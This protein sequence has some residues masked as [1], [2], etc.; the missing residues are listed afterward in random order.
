MKA[1]D[2]KG[3]WTPNEFFLLPGLNFCDRFVLSCIYGLDDNGCTAGDDYIGSL[4]AATKVQV[5]NSINKMKRLGFIQVDCFRGKGILGTQRKIYCKIMVETT[6]PKRGGGLGNHLMK[7]L[8]GMGQ[9]GEV[10]LEGVQSDSKPTSADFLKDTIDIHKNNTVQKENSD[11]KIALENSPYQ[12]QLQ[13]HEMEWRPM[14]GKHLTSFAEKAISLG[15]PLEFGGKGAWVEEEFNRLVHRHGEDRLLIVLRA[16]VSKC[17]AK[18]PTL[19]FNFFKQK[20]QD[21]RL[22]E[23]PKTASTSPVKKTEAEQIAE[24]KK[25]GIG[26][27][28][29][30]KLTL[31]QNV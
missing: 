9:N 24:F 20:L 3:R 1:N 13:T 16:S 5:R 12:T 31:T 25:M 4:I 17:D 8:G 21:L 29:I 18:Y 11:R 2:Q 14:M 28:P 15:K 7:P 19:S 23:I 27:R 30:P 6:S 22:N 10:V 26:S